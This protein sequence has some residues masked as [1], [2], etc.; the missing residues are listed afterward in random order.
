MK[1]HNKITENLE[2]K[3][4]KREAIFQGKEKEIAEGKWRERA[5][6]INIAK[7]LPKNP[8]KTLKYIP[9]RN[10]I[11]RR[12]QEKANS[13]MQE[14]EFIPKWKQNL[15]VKAVTKR[16]LIGGHTRFRTLTTICGR[17]GSL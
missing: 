11:T 6:S 9:R 15:S 17:N 14:T 5:R 1:K 4:K 16:G 8:A 2:G 3:G 7:Y 10:C 12:D 13:T